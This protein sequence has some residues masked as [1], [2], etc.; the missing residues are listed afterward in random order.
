MLTLLV[1]TSFFMILTVWQ[2]VQLDE[3]TEENDGLVLHRD[4]CSIV[5]CIKGKQHFFE[6]D[7]RKTN[8]QL[9]LPRPCPFKG[10]IYMPGQI[11]QQ[12]KN[13]FLICNSGQKLKTVHI[14]KEVKEH[15]ITATN[16]Y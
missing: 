14:L 11:I 10:E 6:I 2:R 15:E 12:M 9:D 16:W 13:Q 5:V 1:I 4:G 3:C 8:C 7:H